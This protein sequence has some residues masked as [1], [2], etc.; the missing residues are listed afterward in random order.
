MN[1][2]L[3]IILIILIGNYLLELFVESLNVRHASNILPREFDS[4]YDADKYKK[5]QNYLKENTNFN[6]IREGFFTSLTLV[7]ILAG[8][9]NFI[10]N[11]ARGFNFGPLLTGLIFAAALMLV[12]RFL[13][14]PFF[15]YR[16][17]VIEEKYGFNRTKVKTF[18]LDILKSLIIGAIIGGVVFSLV[19][20]IFGRAGSRAWFY[21]WLGVA[22]F[23]LFLVFIGPVVILPL[24]NKFVP[25]EE[26]ELKE[27]IERYAASD[28]FKIKGIF[29]I[30]ASR[31]SSK[32][33]AY[34]TGFGKYRRIALFDTLIAKHS[35][36]E[37]V[38]VLAHE[39]GHYKRRHII[40]NMA[41][42]LLSMGAMFYLLSLFINNP[43]LF[44]AFKMEKA[45]IYAGIFFFNFLYIPVAMF[46]SI[47]SNYFSRRYEYQ[48]DAYAVSRYGRPEAFI[49]A[50][51]KLSVDNLSNLTPHPL[52]VF[53]DYSHP[54]VLRRIEAIRQK[55]KIANEG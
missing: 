54:P 38:S 49:T 13:N 50:L 15:A 34:F 36:E 44:A 5:S 22:V 3:V 12:V 29:R 20:W 14:I 39:I 17:F 30:D 48:A 41:I 2:Y 40:K 11:F 27:A 32:S 25:L 33:N 52:K 45:S 26:G 24:F 18:I 9:F 53:L 42:S 43:G 10:D 16:T 47:L 51:K 23:Q 35:V 46:F 37:L 8:G 28:N 19:L 4:Y 6:L 55:E 7:F 31:R 21:C 1:I